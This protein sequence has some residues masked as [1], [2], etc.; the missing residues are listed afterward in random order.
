MEARTHG[1]KEGKKLSPMLERDSACKYNSSCVCRHVH[2]TYTSFT[3][4]SVVR[5]LCL[6]TYRCC[7][8]GW[9]LPWSQ[10]G[11]EAQRCFSVGWPG[12]SLGLQNLCPGPVCLSKFPKF[13][14]LCRDNCIV[15]TKL[16]HPLGC[17]L[18]EALP[19]NSLKKSPNSLLL[20]AIGHR[21]PL[22][23]PGRVWGTG[24][25]DEGRA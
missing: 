3:Y 13:D 23:V 21:E 8:T 4:S 10:W 16:A 25:H 11:T 24:F 20:C 12:A 15:K 7:K 14:T 2:S 5:C 22:A 17:S 6:D 19:R 18:L 1:R 9:S